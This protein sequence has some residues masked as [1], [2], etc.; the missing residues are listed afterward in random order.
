MFSDFD[1]IW[2][3]GLLS[4]D[5]LERERERSGWIKENTMM[6]RQNPKVDK[7]NTKIPLIYV[8]F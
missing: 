6:F 1:L 5:Y 8:K 3:L 4:T 7:I 2:V